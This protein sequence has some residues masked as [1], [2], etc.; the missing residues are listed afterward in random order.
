MRSGAARLRP[1]KGIHAG[2]VIWSAEREA[3][4]WCCANLHEEIE[5]PS[6][7]RFHAGIPHDC[8]NVRCQQFL[9]GI[10][11]GDPYA[12]AEELPG[13]GYDELR[14]IRGQVADK[15]SGTESGDDNKHPLC[16]FVPQPLDGS[17]ALPK[18]RPKPIGLSSGVR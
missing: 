2:D 6:W 11:S 15:N 12:A 3:L 18:A 14:R 1:T 7:S 8:R 13:R 4:A 17:H 10:H 16:F 9:S 5:M